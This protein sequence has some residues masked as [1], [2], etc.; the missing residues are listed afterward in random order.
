MILN[1]PGLMLLEG[2]W[3]LALVIG[4]AG[5]GVTEGNQRRKTMTAKINNITEGV[6]RGARSY[7]IFFDDDSVKTI[8]QELR[9]AS[10]TP[11][12]LYDDLMCG[13]CE[14]AM[15]DLDNRA[16]GGGCEPN[17]YLKDIQKR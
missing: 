14:L 8:R 11:W 6:V 9:S 12:N 2:H 1:A 5:P 13:L 15:K 3:E 4:P 17:N 16:K 10:E 7:L